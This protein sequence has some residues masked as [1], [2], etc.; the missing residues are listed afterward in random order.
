[1]DGDGHDDGADGH[2]DDH[3]KLFTRRGNIKPMGEMLRGILE[4]V[5]REQDRAI[6]TPEIVAH[7][8]T[9]VDLTARVAKSKGKILSELEKKGYLERRGVGNY[10]VTALA[11]GVAD[12]LVNATVDDGVEPD[13][14]KKRVRKSS[15]GAE[16]SAQ[17]RKRSSKTTEDAVEAS[18]RAANDCEIALE[19]LVLEKSILEDKLRE[20]AASMARIQDDADDK[21]RLLMEATAAKLAARTEARNQSPG[22]IA[23]TSAAAR[24]RAA[25]RA[26]EEAETE[27]EDD[28]KEDDDK[29]DDE[30]TSTVDI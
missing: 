8:Q 28:D 25:A 12:A 18:F 21:L 7:F 24:D 6:T 29:A 5:E 11:I 4:V 27:E 23:E 15:D 9:N 1:M 13:K 2:V 26:I 16:T 14:A 20:N 22:A 30:P 17:G 3:P 19:D 10:H